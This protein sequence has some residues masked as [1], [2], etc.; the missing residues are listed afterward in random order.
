MA[1]AAALSVV[2]LNA[3]A[4]ANTPQDSSTVPFIVSTTSGYVVET[5]GEL[6]V[7]FN[8]VQLDTS[9]PQAYSF[10]VVATAASGYAITQLKW[11]FGDGSSIVVPYCCESQ[12]TEVQYHAYQQP[13]SYSVVVVACDSGGNC[14]DAAVTVNWASPVPEY[15]NTAIPILGAL[16]ASML[17]LGYAKRKRVSL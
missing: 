4:A 5:G 10:G 11:S 1:L 14:G 13:G 2:S 6:A 7:N 12:V 16:L 9:S 15:S 17:T 3:A 8:S